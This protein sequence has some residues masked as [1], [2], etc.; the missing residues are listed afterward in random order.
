MC[1][2]NGKEIAGRKRL[3]KGRKEINAWEKK[4][5]RESEKI[6]SGKIKE[7]YI[8]GEKEKEITIGNEKFHRLNLSGYGMG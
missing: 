8:H 4:G 5:E 3:K 6:E 1:G 7:G 2:R